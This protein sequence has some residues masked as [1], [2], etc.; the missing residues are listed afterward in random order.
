M[1]ISRTFLVLSQYCVLLMLLFAYLSLLTRQKRPLGGSTYIERLHHLF[2]HIGQAILHP[3]VLSLHP[4]RLHC[5]STF[6]RCGSAYLA[7][8]GKW[9]GDQTAQKRYFGFRIWTDGLQLMYI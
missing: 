4:R 3:R 7:N 2:L 8:V 6:L 1:R 9:R 5:P